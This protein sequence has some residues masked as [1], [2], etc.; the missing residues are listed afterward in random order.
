MVNGEISPAL[1]QRLALTLASFLGCFISALDPAAREDWANHMVSLLS[2]EG[3]L[4]T[5][6]FPIVEKVREQYVKVATNA[7]V[8]PLVCKNCVS[9]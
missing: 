2:P 7:R 4:V 1:D 6:I 9:M 5:L 3:E 8:F